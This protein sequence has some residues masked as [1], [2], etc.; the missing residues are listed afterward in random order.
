MAGTA[1]P[2]KIGPT[3]PTGPIGPIS[4]TTGPTGPLGEI[5]GP[6]GPLGSETGPTGTIGSTGPTGADSLITGPT[7][8]IVTGP[9]GVGA[10]SIITGPT[11]PV[12]TG[13]TGADSLT[14]GPTGPIQT[15]PTGADSLITGPT[16]PL[17]ST[18]PTGTQS[19]TTGPTGPVQTGPTG[20]TSLTTGPTGPEITGPT[21]SKLAIVKLAGKYRS[22]ICIESPEALFEDVTTVTIWDE[23]PIEIDPLFVEACEPGT[24]KI[25]ACWAQGIGIGHS[26][27][28]VSNDQKTINFYADEV[29]ATFMLKNGLTLTI[30]MVGH[31]RGFVQRFKEHTKEQADAN[32]AFWLAAIQ[33]KG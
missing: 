13:P 27:C 25:T 5:T 3:G 26:S 15:G 1:F 23:R 7:G 33:H 12:Q 24:I 32:N 30:T 19:I 31:R 9:T 14:T 16:G 4:E 11:G 20:A 22:L 2:L 29:V 10:D 17:N 6:T 28:D 8:S 18:G 21:G